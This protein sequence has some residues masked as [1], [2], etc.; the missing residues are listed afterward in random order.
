MKEERL[1]VN[2]L[3]TIYK[4]RVADLSHQNVILEARLAA[5]QEKVYVDSG[6]KK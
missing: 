3:L 4:Q 6:K 5:L 1:N 2:H